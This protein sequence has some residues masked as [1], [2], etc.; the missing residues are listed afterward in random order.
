MKIKIKKNILLENLNIINNG[1]STKNLLPQLASILIESSDLGLKFTSSNNNISINTT[2]DSENIEEISFNGKILIPGK[3]FVEIIKKTDDDIINIELTDNNRVLIHTKSYDTYLNSIDA[4]LFPEISFEKIKNPIKIS[5]ITFKKIVDKVG[6]AANL[7]ED[8]PILKGIN[9]KLSTNNIECIATDTHRLSKLNS[10]LEN[11]T[12]QNLTI[13]T[14]NLSIL[15]NLLSDDGELEFHIFDN[16]IN[17]VFDNICFISKILNGNY[18][19]VSRNFKTE[20]STVI[21]VD[22]HNLIKSLERTSLFTNEVK[23]EINNSNLYL[24]TGLLEIGNIN[25]KLNIEC[26]TGEKYK[27]TMSVKNILDALK[28]FESKII[29][30]NFNSPIEPVIIKCD[31]NLNLVQLIV[32]IMTNEAV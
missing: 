8:R 27:I 3:F 25:E 9:F 32:P 4:S 14:G 31:E 20:F 30:M 16:Y 19:D 10:E 29:T 26:V 21:N 6:F 22:R 13:S 7:N 5:K 11:S 17:F 12:I 15:K 23:F 28:A 1:V 24:T 18:P 2:V